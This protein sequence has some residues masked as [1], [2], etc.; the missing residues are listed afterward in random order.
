MFRFI[1]P[2][3]TMPTAM[4]ERNLKEQMEVF[5]R[6]DELA[7]LFDLLKTDR[8]RIGKDYNGRE[9][10]NGR[11]LETQVI[12]PAEK[13]E[14]LR[15]K[16]YPLLD[17]LGFFRINTPLSRQHSRILVLGGAFHTCFTRTI[18]G[19]KWKD[20]ATLSVDG[21]SCYRPINPQERES[22]SFA[23]SCDT[24]FGVLSDA[25]SEVFGL[26]GN[27]FQDAFTGGRNL[28]EISCIREF[29]TRPDNCLFRIYAAPSSEPELRRA[30]TADTLKFY[31]EEAS[32]LPGESLLAITDNR[33]SNRQFLQ[34]A[35]CII[36]NDLAVDLDVIGCSPDEKVIT[37]ETYDPF[38]F[39]QD[40][41]GILDWIGRF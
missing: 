3:H 32:V 35:H 18:F 11:V 16:L 10:E 22:S 29:S 7:E 31:A 26:S 6:S 1:M 34:L 8:T 28:N 9:K 20:S 13:L 23:S 39:L 12:K 21:L 38:Q 15:E 40:L 36:K 33:Y 24:E 17:R 19:A 37:V 41:I 14:P 25:F 30:D 27:G 4:R 2:E 5:L